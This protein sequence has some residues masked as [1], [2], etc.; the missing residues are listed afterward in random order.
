MHRMQR[1]LHLLRRGIVAAALLLVWGCVA[2]DVTDG[3]GAPGDLSRAGDAQWPSHGGGPGEQRYR[4]LSSIDEHNVDTLGL[5]WSFDLGTTRGVEAT[6]LVV[7]GTLFVTGPWSVVYALDARTGVLRWRH[8]PQVPRSHARYTCCGVVNRGAAYHEGRVFV[9]TLD[10]RLVALDAATGTRLWSV[11]TTEE[12]WPYT[13]TGA[14]RVVQD[15]VVIGN[16]GAEFGVRGYVSAYRS[17]DGSLAWRTYTVPGDPSLG[18]ESPALERAEATWTGEFWKAG[19]GGTVWDSMAYDPALDLLYVGTGNGSPHARWIRSPDGGDN[20]YLSSILALRPA[21]GELVWPFQTTPADTWDYTATQHMILADLEIDGRTRRVLMQAPKNGFFYVIDRESGAFIS[22]APY[23]ALSWATG[24]DEHG[25]PIESAAHDFQHE[26]RMVHPGPF[27]GHN[28][29]PMSFHPETGLVYLPT[30]EIASFYKVDE[31]FALRRGGLNTGLDYALFVHYS[32]EEEADVQAQLL[33][34][35]PLKQEA[36]WRVTHGAAYNGGTLAT[37]GN[38]VFQGSADG[39]LVAYRA[40][41]GTRLW[42]APVGTGVMAAPITYEIDGEQYVAIAAGWG[43][44]FAL[45]AG[46]AALE[47]NVRGGGRVLAFRLGGDA[48]L[49]DAAPPLPAPP[50]APLPVTA[51]EEELLQGSLLFHRD[52]M[53]CHGPAGIAG[54]S[55]RDLRH[56][57]AATHATFEDIVLRGARQ[58]LGMPSFEGLLSRDEVRLIQQYLLHRAEEAARAPRAGAPQS[59]P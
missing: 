4:A 17:D 49:P 54:G 19:G 1:G 31:G 42:E 33:A 7:D 58:P 2:N 48:P 6:P 9:G 46:P 10:G 16:G 53:L 55:I 56:A 22:G 51:S 26:G 47:A 37:G 28:W 57:S 43:S 12:D 50:G 44:G 18:Q 13:I 25:R 23:V 35:D 24:L 8:D 11:V 29:Q 20:L 27:G 38:L 21:T 5:A 52:C 39:R 40:T 30:H 15:L 45:S 36:A 59:S 34:W 3:G 41:D 14:P 32:G